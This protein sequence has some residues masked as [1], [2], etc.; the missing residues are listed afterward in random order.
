M[1]LR[2]WVVIGVVGTALAVL[3]G[4]VTA[5]AMRP[6]AKT[7]TKPEPPLPA[8]YIADGKQDLGEVWESRDAI[9]TVP[10]SN[11]TDKP[12]EILDFESS[13]DC[14]VVSARDITVPAQGSVSVSVTTDLT[15]RTPQQF[16]MAKR[17]FSISLKPVLKSSSVKQPLVNWMVIAKCLIAFETHEI[18]YSEW[19]IANQTPLERS[20]AGVLHFQ[21]GV[22][23]VRSSDPRQV[24]ARVE[25]ATASGIK[26]IVAPNTR[27]GPGP[28]HCKLSVTV[29]MPNGE[30]HTCESIS[31]SGNLLAN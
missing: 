1:S 31:V 30:S 15:K 17:K 8:L 6:D 27:I 13:C 19:C 4:V 22:V 10:I 26:I 20:V 2:R 18:Y 28:F 5:R 24:T 3:S 9:L 14:V 29:E 25:R 21:G 12:I 23:S 11:R 7:D 16:G